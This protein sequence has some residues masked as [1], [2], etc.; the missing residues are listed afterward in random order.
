MPPRRSTRVLSR[1][2]VSNEASSQ[3]REEAPR[4]RGRVR[5]RGQGRRGR[6]GVMP[7]V[8]VP[9]AR[10]GNPT[11]A[12]LAIGLQNVQQV[13]QQI[14]NRF[15][16]QGQPHVEQNQLDSEH[17]QEVVQDEQHPVHRRV[18]EVSLT[19]FVKMDPPTFSGSDVQEDPQVFL[20][21]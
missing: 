14:A 6:A 20:D 12:E 17:S 5:R 2:A 16:D 11:L 3:P 8:E 15:G 10:R 13:V 7:E 9:R 19:S 21:E 18:T 4:G 1:E